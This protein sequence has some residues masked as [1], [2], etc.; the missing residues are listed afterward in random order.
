MREDRLGQ[1]NRKWGEGEGEE[2]EVSVSSALIRC[3]SLFH[4]LLLPRARGKYRKNLNLRLG[5]PNTLTPPSPKEEGLRHA[6]PPEEDP[7]SNG[8]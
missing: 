7:I 2:K 1:G 6:A 8:R 4:F 5:R 3:S